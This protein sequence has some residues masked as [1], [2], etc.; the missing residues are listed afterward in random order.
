MAFAILAICW[1]LGLAFIE[2]AGF[3]EKNIESG[4]IQYSKDHFWFWIRVYHLFGFLW[5]ANFF[6]ACQHM[7][8]AGAVAG[9]YF[10]RD[11]KKLGKIF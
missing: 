9:W 10:C 5:M 11:K 6:V 4:Y 1:T 2:T 7:V 8:T 3:P